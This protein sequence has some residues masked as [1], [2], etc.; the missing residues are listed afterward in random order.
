MQRILTR[1]AASLQLRPFILRQQSWQ[2]TVS[3]AVSPS[4][5]AAPAASTPWSET[6]KTQLGLLREQP[7]NSFSAIVELK[8]RPY[9]VGI[10]DIIV[11]MRMND[12]KLGDV[13]VLDR[14]REIGSKD[15]VLKG[16]PYVHPQF[17]SVKAVVIEHPVSAEVVRH[18]WKKR[19]HQPV[20][21]NRNHH[22]SLRIA[23][24]SI[25]DL[26]SS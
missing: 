23:E 11:T 17:F 12:L 3:A 13:I 24:I 21:T 25:K 5:T 8:Q 4:Q 2:S 20:H 22:T 10:G 1:S 19:G 9:F 6:T 16:H 18:H 7:T 15:Y 14:V 26:G